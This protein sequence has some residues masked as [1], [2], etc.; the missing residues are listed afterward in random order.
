MNSITTQSKPFTFGS[1]F[2]A[3]TAQS[4]PFTFG[5]SFGATPKKQLDEHDLRLDAKKE[6]IQSQLDYVEA[7]QEWNDAQKEFKRAQQYWNSFEQSLKNDT[8]G[9]ALTKR[10][11]RIQYLDVKQEFL[12]A[13]ID[14][15]DAEREWIEAQETWECCNVNAKE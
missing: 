7:E 14:H 15:C 6:Y 10:K 8:D 3:T 12:Q 5:S 13:Q 11:N 1:S 9:C 2:G 4:K